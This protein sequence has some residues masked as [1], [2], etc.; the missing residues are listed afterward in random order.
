MICYFH[1]AISIGLFLELCQ[2]PYLFLLFFPCRVEKSLSLPF[3]LLF[4]VIGWYKPIVSVFILIVIHLDGDSLPFRGPNPFLLSTDFVGWEAHAK[5]LRQ[6]TT[7]PG[8]VMCH[9]TA[10]RKVVRS[11]NVDYFRQWVNNYVK[12]RSSATCVFVMTN[13]A[14]TPVRI[15]CSLIRQRQQK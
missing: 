6:N 1:V 9:V 5:T 11:V 2:I 4:H 13:Q 3:F 14:C 15:L 7:P 8:E 10:A 12:G